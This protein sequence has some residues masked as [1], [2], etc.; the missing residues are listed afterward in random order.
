MALTK[1]TA[2]HWSVNTV[3]PTVPHI[4]QYQPWGQRQRGVEFGRNART[5]TAN[6]CRNC[7]N[8]VGRHRAFRK[9]PLYR[10]SCGNVAAPYHPGY[11]RVTAASVELRRVRQKCAVF[12]SS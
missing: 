10:L 9:P 8:S 3:G 5:G 7:T 4:S 12:H 2:V 11:G 6:S 1:T